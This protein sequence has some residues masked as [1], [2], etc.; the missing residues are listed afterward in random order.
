MDE[1]LVE[2]VILCGWRILLIC[3]LRPG[4]GRDSCDKA[5]PLS[6]NPVCKGLRY[7]CTPQW[8]QKEPITLRTYLLLQVYCS[9]SFRF[10]CV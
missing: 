3:W 2:A 1:V 4:N 7:K 8:P 10:V 5:I 9:V 6:A